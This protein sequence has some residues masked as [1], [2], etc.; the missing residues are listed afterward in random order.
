MRG[1]DLLVEQLIAEGVEIVFGLPGIQI[2]AV[3]DALHARS[4]SIAVLHTR[5][6]QGCGY[7]AYGYAKATGRLGVVRFEMSRRVSSR[8]RS[9]PCGGGPPGRTAR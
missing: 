8:P 7:M 1:A 2:M 4:S 3:F 5:H 9:G 6:E